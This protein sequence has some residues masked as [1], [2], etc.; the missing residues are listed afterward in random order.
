LHVWVSS[1]AVG[2]LALGAA[3]A[4]TI[5]L[6]WADLRRSAVRRT[7]LPSRSGCNP[8]G[9]NRYGETMRTHQPWPPVIATMA[10]AMIL[11]AMT[12]Q[13]WGR[14]L[15]PRL[16]IYVVQNSVGLFF[17]LYAGG[18]LFITT[19][20]HR[21][22]VAPRAAWI[23]M[24]LISLSFPALYW[25]GYL[26]VVLVL[27]LEPLRY[28][29]DRQ[30]PFMIY[31]AMVLTSALGARWVAAALTKLTGRTDRPLRRG[32]VLWG[33]LWPFVGLI[34][35][36]AR[37]SDTIWPLFDFSPGSVLAWQLP[38]GLAGAAW[39]IRAER[40]CSGTAPP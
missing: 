12:P 6:P 3:R 38:I 34:A 22:V 5:T 23:A 31:G 35:R 37:I 33:A 4:T 13:V 25:G 16:Q 21:V 20:W 9:G 40:S 14:L 28:P 17:A 19:R 8:N 27:V 11:S 30:L 29:V 26:L 15:L 36:A 18:A 24:L 10:I 32:M 39:F 2:L 7:S 1:P